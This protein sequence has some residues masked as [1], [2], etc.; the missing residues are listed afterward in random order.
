[1]DLQYCLGKANV[2][3]DSLSRHPV[4]YQLTT[5]RHI[6]QNLDKLGIEVVIPGV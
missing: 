1:M 2:V 6:L 5:Q 4:V 3:A